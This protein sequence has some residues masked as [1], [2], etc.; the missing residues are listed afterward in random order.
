MFAIPLQ[1]DATLLR[2]RIYFKVN[3]KG[4][5]NP[6]LLHV[7]PTE[8]SLLILKGCLL[9]RKIKLQGAQRLPARNRI[10]LW[11]FFFYLLNEEV[12]AMILL[13]SCAELA[14]PSKS[15]LQKKSL[16]GE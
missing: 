9:E 4:R 15:H 14:L 13:I 7:N 5:K 3:K 2:C 11:A 10:K 6:H 12:F 1:M 8:R 16:E